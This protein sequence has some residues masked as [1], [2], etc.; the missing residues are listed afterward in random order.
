MDSTAA[1]EININLPL[2]DRAITASVMPDMN[3]NS[4]S[5]PQLAKNGCTCQLQQSKAI[6]TCGDTTVISD[7]DMETGLRNIPIEL[8]NENTNNNTKSIVPKNEIPN[9]SHAVLTKKRIRKKKYKQ[10][11]CDCR[12][13]LLQL[14]NGT[15]SII[16]QPT[17]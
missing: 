9:P 8:E 5:V 17:K 7:R 4:I 3:T 11:S 15:T 10:S 14:A 13:R 12:K 6:V 1:K 2:S 16:K